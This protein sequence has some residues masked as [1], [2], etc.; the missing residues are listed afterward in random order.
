MNQPG[1]HGIHSNVVAMMLE[2][3]F[4]PDA[5]IREARLP[6]GRARFQ[7]ERES[8]LDELNGALQGDFLSG[9][10]C[11]VKMIGHDDEIMQAVSALVAIVKDHFEEQVGRGSVLEQG[12]SLRG[13]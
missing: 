12:S 3:F 8:S 9:R 5:M 1:A 10:D 11:R 13:D 4:I 7:P 6:D 2:V